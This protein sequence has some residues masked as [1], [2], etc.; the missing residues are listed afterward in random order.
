MNIDGIVKVLEG[1]QQWSST[2]Q[3]A[4]DLEPCPFCGGKAEA[5]ALNPAYGFCGAIVKC[6]QCGA[7]GP[8]ASIYARIKG[9]ALSTL[10]TPNSVEHGISAA[11]STWNS[12]EVKD[13]KALGSLEVIERG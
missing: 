1:H 7:R 10:M 12:R 6:S 5:L 3:D 2:D 9:S 11:V 4:L 8:R 13:R